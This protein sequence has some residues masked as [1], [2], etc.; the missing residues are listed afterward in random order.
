MEA[1]QNLHVPGT[2]NE[3]VDKCSLLTKHKVKM[4]AV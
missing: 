2:V 4:V 3:D 1:S